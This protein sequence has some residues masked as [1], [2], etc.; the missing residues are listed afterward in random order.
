[1]LRNAAM[2]LAACLICTLVGCRDKQPA[3]VPHAKFKALAK[4][5]GI[6]L[7]V[8]YS[9]TGKST[10]TKPV[11]FE[12]RKPEA[13]DSPR[14]ATL[15][16][17]KR[18]PMPDVDGCYSI[19]EVTSDYEYRQDKWVCTSIKCVCVDM[20]RRGGDQERFELLKQAAVGKALFQLDSSAIAYNKDPIIRLLA[21]T[22]D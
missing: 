16:F 22:A 17:T 3:D 6:E 21:D 14:T 19:D 4:K 13:A 9:R 2:L 10:V 18:S 15:T 7:P 8:M 12:V 5:V 20:I 1:M 11:S